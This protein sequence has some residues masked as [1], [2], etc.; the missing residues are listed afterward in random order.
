VTVPGPTPQV[1]RPTATL[2]IFY[3]KH[4]S[5]VEVHAD[6]GRPILKDSSVASADQ[7]RAVWGPFVG[8]AGTFDVSG[9]NVLTMQASVAKNPAAMMNGATSVYTYQ[10]Q[11]DTLTLTHTTT[12]AGTPANP[13]TVKLVRVE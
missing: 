4:Y 11:G 9:G 12:Y 8:E 5:R 6:Q 3:G 7:L 13:V 2:A 1:F 10:R